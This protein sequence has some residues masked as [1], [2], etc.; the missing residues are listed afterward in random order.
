MF[1][2]TIRR[3]FASKLALNLSFRAGP[4]RF[5]RGAARN[6]QS[7][8]PLSRLASCSSKSILRKGNTMVGHD[9]AN[10]TQNM[11]CSF[12]ACPDFFVGAFHPRG[13]VVREG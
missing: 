12:R 2:M 4:E 10:W 13:V 11:I 8:V 1:Q 5:W 9:R 7:A 6:L 3:D